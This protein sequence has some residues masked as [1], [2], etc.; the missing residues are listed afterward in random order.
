MGLMFSVAFQ[1]CDLTF[2]VGVPD[3]Q[4]LLSSLVRELTPAGYYGYTCSFMSR[5]K[6]VAKLP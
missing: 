4:T 3:E 1:S 5:R 6:E 2:E